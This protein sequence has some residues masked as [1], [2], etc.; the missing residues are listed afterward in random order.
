M[1]DRSGV[2]EDP[3]TKGER[4]PFS[5]EKQEYPGSDAQMEPR[6][7]HGEES[8]TGLASPH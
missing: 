6:P 1:A 7:D 2:L 8:Y 3:R 5:G 4:P